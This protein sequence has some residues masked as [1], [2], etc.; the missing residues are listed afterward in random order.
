MRILRALQ[1]PLDTASPLFVAAGMFD[2]VHRGH[3]AVIR[4]A[5]QAAATHQG[6]AWV[7]TFDPHPLAIIAP[8]RAPPTLTPLP[9]RLDLIE[10]L[11]VDGALVVPFTHAFSQL[12]P[13]AFIETL[14]RAMPTLHQI[15]IGPDWRFGR[16]AAGDAARLRQ[17]AAAHG[18][19]AVVAEHKRHHGRKISS[20]TI[21]DAIRAG[22]FEEAR[23]LL[24]RPFTIFGTVV[25]GR[26]AGR[27]L[28][29]P[30]ANII[31]AQ[32]VLPPHGV[33]AVQAEI[34]GEVH[35]GAAYYGHRSINPDQDRQYFLETYLFDMNRDLY[36]KQ[37]GVRLLSFIRP[38]QH[39]DD[40]DAL[41]RQIQRD[42]EAVRAV[43]AREDSEW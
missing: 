3:Q 8:D 30:T 2:G 29:F 28:G 26:Q 24:G 20:T 35:P 5:V 41:K 43:L 37:I 34:D 22:R 21:R 4:A 9:H 13:E 7:L 10:S 42:T 32:D 23:L 18:F 16:N 12:S 17:L 40:E 27:R 1:P 39:F 38:D 25:P 36:Q 6:E 15:L 11:G 19:E 31:P 33:F 14:Q